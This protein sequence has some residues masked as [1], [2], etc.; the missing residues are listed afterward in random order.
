MSRPRL[1][2]NILEM[3]G[4]FVKNPQRRRADADHLG[5]PALEELPAAPEWLN[6]H[7]QREFNRLG[8]I[9]LRLGRLTE[10]NLMLFAHMC[11]L[12]GRIAQLWRGGAQPRGSL[13]SQ[14]R[15]LVSDLGLP[16]ATS[17]IVRG[18]GG[19]TANRFDRFRRK[20]DE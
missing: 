2:S 9:A 5:A 10:A 17:R 6:A 14:H 1:P 12:H 18:A 7:A 11:A 3:R 19:G 20:D 16:S 15:A 13:L 8:A 4:S